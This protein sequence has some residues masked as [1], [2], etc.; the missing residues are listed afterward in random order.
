MPSIKIFEYKGYIAA[1]S[2]MPEEGGVYLND[3]N[4][5]HQIGLI[6]EL[7]QVEITSAA[8]AAIKENHAI[9]GD[10]IGDLMLS[11]DSN[12]VGL[13]GFGKHPL[14]HVGERLVHLDRDSD[15]ESIDRIPVNDEMEIPKDF[16]QFVDS[17][18]S[19]E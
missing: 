12:S 16:I 18:L 2:L 19:A 8:V 4:A 9:S 10:V 15:I 11:K 3:L 5:G 14:G 6:A 17:K 7:N 1:E 13:L